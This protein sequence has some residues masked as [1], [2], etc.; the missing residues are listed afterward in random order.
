M[1]GQALAFN[2]I[3]PVICTYL[4]TPKGIRPLFPASLVE[5][6]LRELSDEPHHNPFHCNRCGRVYPLTGARV[7]G[8]TC[9]QP[10]DGSFACP[11][12]ITRQWT[13]EKATVE[14]QRLMAQG[15]VAIAWKPE[16]VPVPV[17]F[18]VCEVVDQNEVTEAVDMSVSLSDIYRL[19]GGAQK[20]LL[21]THLSL[22][23]LREAESQDALRKL[24]SG[25]LQQEMAR[26]Q[27]GEARVLVPVS[28]ED[29]NREY[30]ALE[31]V[32]SG[33]LKCVARDPDKA[34]NRELIGFKYCPE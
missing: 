1:S 12:V 9:T 24:L 8:K 19:L 2:G 27:P 21:I 30:W 22:R 16:E 4:P 15:G 11:G 32:F 14:L 17:G 7:E 34:R 20:Y 5:M 26:H 23:G 29:G 31:A 6:F 25:L 10:S 13:K 18:A 3:E 33:S 28:T